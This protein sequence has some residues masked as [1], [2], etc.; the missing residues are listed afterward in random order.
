MGEVDPL[1]TKPEHDVILAHYER[2]GPLL[3][4]HFGGTP[5]VAVTYPTGLGR[6]PVYHKSADHV[7]ATITTIPVTTATGTHPYVAL[8]PHNL[9]WLVA[10]HFAVEFHGWSPTPADP[11]R[12]AYARLHLEPN[13]TASD[14]ELVR[15]AQILLSLLDARNLGAIVL[16]DGARGIALW[17]PFDD[18]PPYGA[19][20]AWLQDFADDA[21]HQHPDLLTTEWLIRDR[22]DR[23]WL[24]TRSNHPGIGTI[25]PYA[26]RGTPSLEVAVPIARDELGTRT[27]GDVTVA[28]FADYF[29]AHGDVFETLRQAIPP[30][31]FAGLAPVA[32][33]A[34]PH[35]FDVDL[36]LAPPNPARFMLAAALAVLADDKPHSAED[37]LAQALAR[38]LVPKSTTK[39]YLYTALREY[40]LRALGAGRV[41][42]IVQVDDKSVFRINRPA[43]D[44]PDAMLPPL[45]HWITEAD[46]AAITARLRAT[47]TGADPTAFETAACEAF[48]VLGFLATHLGGNGEPDGILAAPL[49]TDGY[50]VILE[51]KTASLDGIVNNPRAEE[52]AKFREEHGAQYSL[53]LGPAFGNIASLDAEL[54]THKVSLWTV[55]DLVTALEQAIGP[56]EFR[57]PSTPSAAGPGALPAPGSEGASESSATGSDE[58]HDLLAPG[59]VA[60]ALQM[61]LWDRDHG[62]RKRVEVIADLIARLGWQT[63]LTLARG[64]PPTE[65]PALT[66]ETLFVLVDDALVRA[67]VTTG[68][69][70]A[71]AEE[72]LR[73]LQARGTLRPAASGTGYVVRVPPRPASAALMALDPKTLASRCWFGY[74]HWSAPY[75]FIGK[76]PGGTDDPETYASWQRLGGMDLVDCRAHDLEYRG[77]DSGKWHAATPPLQPTWRSL[78]ALLLAYK[79]AIEYDPEA[80]R[81]YQAQEWGRSGGETAVLELSA[82][83]APSTS[84]TESM[85]LM[86][87]AERIAAF[88]ARIADHHPSFVLFYGCGWDAV[89]GKPYSD[90]WNALAGATLA[91]NHPIKVGQTVFVWTKHPT[92]HGIPNEFWTQL[93]RQIRATVDAFTLTDPVAVSPAQ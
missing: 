92:A 66:E 51:C 15:A 48:G 68:A 84:S 21:A 52:A 81:R 91:E 80:V 40:V 76:E 90:Y 64:V 41:P 65:S 45:P 18:A 39:K 54:A 74:G 12:A 2:V 6:D 20:A 10:A 16:L 29:A 8:N 87:V 7:P 67:G 28:N 77:K 23:I 31:N 53:L 14:A 78:I 5:V 83:A 36:D 58:S 27:N 46:L 85:R 38:G 11:A 82:I 22:G 88:K 19:L 61:L 37:I 30:Q 42:E 72:G 4:S 93:G 89:N 71:E 3:A 75:W 44:W 9:T 32:M 24:G 35:V 49:G 34:E 13:G 60:H 56:D 79:G 25:L 43:D 69:S 1:I 62:R 26:L 70:R 33:P 59:R 73:L 63:Q 86:H 50:R 57:P 17:I 47:A 55:D